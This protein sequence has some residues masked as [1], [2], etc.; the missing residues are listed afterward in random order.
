MGSVLDLWLLLLILPIA[1]IVGNDINYRLGK[2][3]GHKLFNKPKS[4]F[5]TPENLAKTQSFFEVHGPKAI[6]IARFAPFVRSFAPFV[7]GM[8]DMSYSKFTF[9]SIVGAYAWIFSFTFLGFFF[10]RI[11]LVQDYLEVAVLIVIFLT[12]IPIYL[13]IRKHR[14]G[15]KKAV[16]SEPPAGEDPPAPE[17]QP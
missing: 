12:L 7:A 14:K 6:V 16:V 5:F 8:A 11:K 1:A 9:Y 17:E 3:L 13:E 15:A 4:R 2:A 10:G